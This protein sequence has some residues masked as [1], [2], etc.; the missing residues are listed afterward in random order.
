M[1]A[2][3]TVASAWSWAGP[4]INRAT[5]SLADQRRVGAEL[6][7]FSGELLG[8]FAAVPFQLGAVELCPGFKL[9][10]L[11]ATAYGRQPS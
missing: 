9:E 2:C 11:S 8:C 4:C 7:L 10:Y 3:V 6:R 5:V 1:S